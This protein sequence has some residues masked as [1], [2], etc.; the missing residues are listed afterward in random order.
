[1]LEWR[2]GRCSHDGVGDA[3]YVS[4][5]PVGYTVEQ[6]T[7][8]AEYFGDYE[9]AFSFG[10]AAAKLWGGKLLGAFAGV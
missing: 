6:S 8:G 1:M 4:G 5:V 2:N 9:D 7:F 10:Y 3:A